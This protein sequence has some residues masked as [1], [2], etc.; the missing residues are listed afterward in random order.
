VRLPTILIL[1]ASAVPAAADTYSRQPYLDV[2]HYE[3][4]VELTD[5]SDRITGNTRIRVRMN[6]DGVTAMWLDFADM[7]VDAL[8]VGQTEMPFEH[9][10]ER[11][12]FRMDRT[13]R[14]GEIA[15][16]AVKYHGAPQ[17]VGLLIGSNKYG[18]RV[19]FAENW[20][21]Q[22]HHWFPAIDH[23]SDKATVDFL[24]IAPDRYD[25]VA[26][27]KLV[28]IRSLQDGRKS[29]HW[30]ESRPI[31]TYSMVIGVAEFATTD[32]G[33]AA[34]IPLTIYAYPQDL[35]NAIRK[36]NR[37]ALALQY[38][39]ALIGRYP[40]EKLAQV[41]STTRIGGME[42]AS[43]IFYS[44]E[45]FQRSRIEE[46]PMPH[47]I[48]HQWFGDS[49]TQN[50]WDHLWLSEGFATYFEALFYEHLE[51]AESMKKSMELAA[52]EVRKYQARHPDPIVDPALNELTKKLNP[53]NYYKGA[54][55]LHMLRK[56]LG[57][58]AF[59]RG[60]RAYY[61]RFKGS[62]ARSE[63]FQRVME[64]TSGRE[65]GI[66]FRQWLYQPGLPEYQLTWRWDVTKTVRIHRKSE[67]FRFPVASRPQAAEVDPNGYILKVV[68]TDSR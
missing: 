61:A 29:V 40:Y 13:Y 57:D 65:L 28:E 62:N 30:S 35:P 43:A 58:D 11:L 67:E 59:F 18:H 15:V 24:I 34:G 46:T 42:N 47:E 45:A 36:F 39:S 7:T 53:L 21:D 38:F 55:V 60:I 68:R 49:V 22:G 6:D 10:D 51:G 33:T 23:P 4:A 19:W 5:H 1:L 14:K 37:S 12:S 50:D 20:P 32:A 66:F 3:V 16:I 2:V 64:E 52:D 27:G 17:G 8:S 56:M 63:D 31:P 48:A 9:R 25:V 44:E 26:N 54:W 41:E